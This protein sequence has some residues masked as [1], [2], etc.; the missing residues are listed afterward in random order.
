LKKLLYL[1]FS[2][3]ILSGCST[4]NNNFMNRSYHHI[5]TKYNV[6]YNGNLKLTEGIKELNKNY[7]DNFWELLP[8]EALKIDESKIELKGENKE[9]TPFDIAEE[10]AVKAVQKHSINIGENEKNK[11]IADAYFLLGRSRYY[12]QRFVPALEA[13][14]YAIKHNPKSK[15]INQL[16]IWK[17]K[18][19]LR[20]QN[21]ENALKELKFLETKSNLKK[22]DQVRL[23]EALA[24]T[25]LALDS[26][27]QAK[28]H[29]QLAADSK[30][31]PDQKA[32]DW[33]VLGQVYKKENQL[34]SARWAFNNIIEN[35]KS[36]L[37]YSTHAY[38]QLIT[39]ASDSL[40]LIKYRDKLNKL[41]NNPISSP[42]K[43]EIYFN[44]AQIYF[45]QSL[46]SLALQ[47]L[48]KSII[49][50]EAKNYQKVLSYEAL[51]D[52]HFNKNNFIQAA[53]YYDSIHPFIE[54]AN[55]KHIKKLE[56]KINNLE[57]VVFFE[58]KIKSNDSILK[59]VAMDEAERNTFFQKYIDQLKEDDKKSAIKLENSQRVQIGANTG[60]DFSDKKNT[61]KWYFYNEQVVDYGKKEFYN[62]WGKRELKNNWRWQNGNSFS[63]AETE[64]K[65][66]SNKTPS[67]KNKEN[68]KYAIDTYL[69]TIPSKTEEIEKLKSEK[70]DALYQLGLIYK[71][72]FEIYSLAKDRLESFLQNE[73]KEKLVL[74]AKF[75]LQKVYE[76]IG[77]RKAIELKEDI[78]EN[79][80]DTRYAAML[81]NKEVSKTDSIKTPEQHYEKVYCDYEYELYNEVLSQCEDAIKLYVDEPI[82][83]KFELLKS[84]ALFHTNGK[85]KFVESLEFVIANFPKTEEAKHAKEVLDRMNGVL[86]TSELNKE[87]LQPNE[88]NKEPIQP[89][90]INKEKV[91]PLNEEEKRQKVLQMIKEKGEPNQEFKEKNG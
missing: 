46:D 23:H 5:T 75:H 63:D 90:E 87:S 40:S 42:F 77:D 48:K 73:P 24:M 91:Q 9:N 60:D 53:Q 80:A 17:A 47:N 59:L 86:K 68:P 67:K 39:I 41:A 31:E 81:L 34:D 14:D 56:N 37:K 74:P 29:L 22:E 88:V 27:L 20:L 26:T 38:F 89:N 49:E 69:S 58:N 1:I 4:Q 79:H 36:P 70:S 10:K 71:E 15:L 52:Y 8:I 51:G 50:P 72:K 55:T 85:D 13:F 54:N 33:F 61:T 82:Q 2:I 3:I 83:P 62:V 65:N 6:L 43:D 25:Y 7:H 32:R 18:T 11:Q 57:D 16:R 35:K 30:L 45:K 76:K 44:L 64:N 84:Y 66:N 78:T 19:L 21:E 28:K 12:S